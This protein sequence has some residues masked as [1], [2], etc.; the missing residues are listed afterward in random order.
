ML[1]A[2]LL[3][4]AAGYLLGSIPVADLV[5]GRRG[6]DLRE[7]GDRNPGYWNA[8]EVVGRRAAI[9]VLAGDAAKGALAAALGRSAA[10]DDE[11]WLPVLGNAGSMFGHCWPL[12]AGFRGGRGV[13]TFAGGAVVISPRSGAIALGLLGAT[14]AATRSFAPAVRVGVAAYP[15]VQLAVDGARRTAATGALMTLIGIR[16]ATA[17]RESTGRQRAYSR[18]RHR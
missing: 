14:W 11:W 13:A 3:V 15:V 7:V 6:A 1:A 8:K 12:F 18:P 17:R 4:P 2:G 16:F 10:R 5:V 9:P